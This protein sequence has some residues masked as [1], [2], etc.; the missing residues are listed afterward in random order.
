MMSI[1]FIWN[2]NLCEQ[3]TFELWFLTWNWSFFPTNRVGLSG[4]GPPGTKNKN[5]L[6]KDKDTGMH[7]ELRTE[8]LSFSNPGPAG[9]CVQKWRLAALCRSQ[10]GCR[11]FGAGR[12][13]SGWSRGPRHRYATSLGPKRKWKTQNCN[14]FTF[15]NTFLCGQIQFKVVL[16]LTFLYAST[17]TLSGKEALAKKTNNQPNNNYITPQATFPILLVL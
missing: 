5:T 13:P 2:S 8:H 9:F 15:Y 7:T 14:T 3:M 4:L 12:S 10:A 17:G 6:H 16:H 1:H 11:R